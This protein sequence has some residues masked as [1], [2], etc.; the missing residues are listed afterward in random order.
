M[1]PRFKYEYCNSFGYPSHR[2]IAIGPDFA[3]DFHVCDHDSIADALERYI[4]GIEVHYRSPP[5]Y[6]NDS[7]P[8]HDY[9]EILK[10]PCWHDWSSLQASDVWIPRWLSD[11]YNHDRMFE[12]LKEEMECRTE[13]VREKLQE[14]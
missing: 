1:K 2:W 10:C 8:S 14:Y 13:T 12:F 9:C 7:A 3:L 11:P 6:M 5:V 4:G